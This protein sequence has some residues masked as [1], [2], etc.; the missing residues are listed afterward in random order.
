MAVQLMPESA[1]CL[2]MVSLRWVEHFQQCLPSVFVS[3]FPSV[4]AF[5]ITLSVWQMPKQPLQ[6][7]VSCHL[8]RS[9]FACVLLP[10]T[11]ILKSSD[12]FLLWLRGCL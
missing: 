3:F 10:F 9:N 7:E 1:V 2:L 8:I 6:Q 5:F 11:T 4:V 12:N